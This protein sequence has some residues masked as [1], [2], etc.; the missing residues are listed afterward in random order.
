MISVLN[1]PKFIGDTFSNNYVSLDTN[2]I[3]LMGHSLGGAAI[4]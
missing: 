3:V 4:L 1:N 2:N